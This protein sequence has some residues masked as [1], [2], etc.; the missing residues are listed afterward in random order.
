MN[1]IVSVIQN[2]K[3]E[4]IELYADL[5]GLTI[6]GG[7]IPADIVATV[8]R[9]DI[10]I[11]DRNKKLVELGELTV[12]FEPNID[13]ARKRKEEKYSSLVVDIERN[14]FKCSLTCF[15]VG[16]RGLVTK[17]TDEGSTN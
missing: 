1:Y 13:N 3:K 2:E 17:E 5:P 16:S 11:I 6:N 8:E 9:P 14:G 7:T 4:C 15:E 12:P 10:V